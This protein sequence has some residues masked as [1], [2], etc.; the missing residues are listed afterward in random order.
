MIFDIYQTSDMFGSWH[1]LDLQEAMILK[2]YRKSDDM[3]PYTGK[4]T[5]LFWDCPLFLSSRNFRFNNIL[6]LSPWKHI[7][8]GEY[9]RTRMI[10]KGV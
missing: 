1:I 3:N 8:S 9:P 2:P 4:T 10:Y 6:D 7:A 5:S